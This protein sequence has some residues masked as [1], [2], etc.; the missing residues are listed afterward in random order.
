MTK[1][2]KATRHSDEA[3]LVMVSLAD[4]PKHGYAMIKDIANLAGR[5]LGPGTLYGAITRLERQGCIEPISS[6]DR[7][8]VYRLTQ[9]GAQ[10]LRS[11]LDRHKRVARVGLLRLAR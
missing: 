5:R 10:I 3:L 1:D 6:D 11:E 4:G 2:A 8:R 7:R 9:A